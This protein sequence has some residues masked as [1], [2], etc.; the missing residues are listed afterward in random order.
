MLDF[1]FCWVRRSDGML[2]A[3]WKVDG[4]KIEAET[5]V[6]DCPELGYLGEIVDYQ[7]NRT[8]A[9]SEEGAYFLPLRDY[10]A[11]LK[12]KYPEKEAKRLAI[13]YSFE[14]GKRF[15]SH[16]KTW[17]QLFL[18]VR[19]LCED[20]QLSFNS[21]GGMESDSEESYFS[22][23][24]LELAQDAIEEAKQKA[25]QIQLRHLSRK[26]SVIEFALR[27]AL[28]N[29]GDIED[30]CEDV[31]GSRSYPGSIGTSEDLA[32]E[33]ESVLSSFANHD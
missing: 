9:T 11:E 21:M 29:I 16:G 17:D 15:L 3:S 10:E 27:Y 7:D 26:A 8:I 19:V 23:C 5:I 20:V 28:S 33:I 30:C 32:Q 13:N 4:F 14:D 6:D 31:E 12:D 1:P 25:E 2:C 24:A 18:V 22:K